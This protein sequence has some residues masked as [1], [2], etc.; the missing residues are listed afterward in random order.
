MNSNLRV[1]VDMIVPLALRPR[2]Q[3]LAILENPRNLPTPTAPGAPLELAVHRFKRWA[4]GRRLQIR[5]LDGHPVVQK[6]VSDWAEKWT[7]HAN[8]VFDFGDHENADIRISFTDLGSWSYIGTD[9]RTISQSKATMNFGW[10]MPN[11]PDQT[12]AQVVLHE[13]G[14][15]IGCIHEHQAPAAGISWNKAVVYD[16][17]INVH[18][19]TKQEVDTNFFQIYATSS[20]NFSTFDPHSIM[21]YPI[22]AAFTTNGFEILWNS[23]LSEIDK[24]FVATIYPK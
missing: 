23:Q 2:A 16:Y 19:W 9:A 6:R 8:L 1:D 14:H 20:T 18:H 11:S 3:Q 4:N 7:E 17:Y 24:Q 13:F 5:F 22:P 12:Y 21:V 15:A 10:L